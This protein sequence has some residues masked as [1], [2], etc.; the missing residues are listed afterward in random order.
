MP[1]QEVIGNGNSMPMEASKVLEKDR[2]QLIEFETLSEEVKQMPNSE[3]S[4]PKIVKK[5]ID[6]SMKLKHDLSFASF[7]DNKL[8]S[9]KKRKIKDKLNES[10]RRESHCKGRQLLGA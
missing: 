8:S 7:L 10:H 2:K 5:L 9:G 6:E 4:S 1:F 3:L